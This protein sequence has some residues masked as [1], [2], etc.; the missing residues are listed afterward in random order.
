MTSVPAELDA[1]APVSVPLTG[2]DRC[3]SCGAQ[4]YVRVTLNS[5]ELLFCAHH[6]NKF[7]DQLATT[8][9]A[10]DDQTSKLSE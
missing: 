4:A 3:D 2:F 8:A 10:W 6:A 1:Q 7:K 5:G 9:L